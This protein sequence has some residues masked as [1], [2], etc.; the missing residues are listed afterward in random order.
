MLNP[1]FHCNHTRV[2]QDTFV[3]TKSAVHLETYEAEALATIDVGWLKNWACDNNL[4]FTIEG[5]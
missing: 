3:M 5:I 4:M 2:N 1:D